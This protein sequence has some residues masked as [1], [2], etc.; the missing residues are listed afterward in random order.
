MCHAARFV[1]EGVCEASVVP[2]MDPRSLHRAFWAAL[3]LVSP[4]CASERPN[5]MQ[6]VPV[7]QMPGAAAG[8]TTA[9]DA[10]QPAAAAGRESPPPLDAATPRT[11]A[12]PAD[13]APADANAAMPAHA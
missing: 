13:A 11:D 2:P 8:G 5:K 7:G 3:V 9:V 1:S 10:M 4:S 12:A 6:A